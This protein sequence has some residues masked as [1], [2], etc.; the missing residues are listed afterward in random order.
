[1]YALTILS[2]LMAFMSII[3]IYAVW[4]EYEKLYTKYQAAVAALRKSNVEINNI[5]RSKI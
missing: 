2:L 3:A 5:T 4:Y 1:M